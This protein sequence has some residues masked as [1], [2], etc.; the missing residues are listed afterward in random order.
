K[1]GEACGGDVLPG[2]LTGLLCFGDDKSKMQTGKC[3]P[4]KDL[5]VGSEGQP[6]TFFGDTPLLCKTDNSCPLISFTPMCLARVASGGA[7]QL[8]IPDMCPEGEYCNSGTC[9]P[10][11]GAGEPCAGGVVLKPPCSAYMRCVSGTCRLLGDNGNTCAVAG[12]CY[13]GV[14]DAGRCAAPLCQ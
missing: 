12:E 4:A 10:L 2:C 11:P 13:S 9:A 8:A 14:C 5:F 3:F 7:C 1:E 6:C